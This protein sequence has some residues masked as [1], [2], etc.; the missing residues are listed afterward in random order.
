LSDYHF[1]GNI[2]ELENMMERAFILADN[3]VLN[4]DMFPLPG[5]KVSAKENELSLKDISKRARNEAE[6]D[7]IVDALNK[8]NWNRVKAAENLKV[9][10]KTLRQKIKELNIL[11]QYDRGRRA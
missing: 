2:R 7:V 5:Q 6:R 8:T 4:V 3:N 9:D 10:Y 11:P 1:P